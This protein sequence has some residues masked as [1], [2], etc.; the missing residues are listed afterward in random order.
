MQLTFKGGIVAA[1]M[2]T[3]FKDP[4]TTGAEYELMVPSEG[5]ANQSSTPFAIASKHTLQN[6]KVLLG[7]WPSEEGRTTYVV[8]STVRALMTYVSELDEEE[9]EARE[10]DR[11]ANGWACEACTFL[12]ENLEV[13]MY[14]WISHQDSCDIHV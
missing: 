11:T 6:G 2:M 14:L 13:N 1:V 7:T 5:K 4:D 12:N 3:L 9:G 10:E 8:G